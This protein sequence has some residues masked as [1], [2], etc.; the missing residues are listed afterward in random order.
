MKIL[1]V[2]P[3]VFT[4]GMEVHISAL[5]L[6]LRSKG[7]DTTLV[8]DE[9]FPEDPSK[10]IEVFNSGVRIVA[11]P[12]FDSFNIASRLLAQLKILRQ[13]LK[14]KS[15][16]VVFCEGY[17]QSLPFYTRYVKRP[18]GKLIFHDHMDGV[19][20][21]C[22]NGGGFHYPTQHPYNAF[23]RTLI[24]KS[25]LIIAGCKRAS[26]NFKKFYLLDK[27]TFLA[28]A[29]LPN[30]APK[31]AK[32]R[33]LNNRRIRIGVFGYLKPQ[34]GTG[35][36]LNL[37]PKLNIG[38]AELHFYGSDCGGYEEEAK[39]MGIDN[40]VFHPGYSHEDMPALMESTDLALVLSIFEGYPLTLLE[41]MMFGVPVVVTDV[42]AAPEVAEGCP[43]IRVARLN[44]EDVKCAIE[45]H[46]ANLRAGKLSRARIQNHYSSRFSN[47][48]F[49]QQYLSLIA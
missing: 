9:R 14:P 41:C 37:W 11:F 19:I 34:K 32:E 8:V 47:E 12:D 30:F 20:N 36:L 5:A 46:V 27:P 2:A 22:S 25:D 45:E 18:G 43:D 35:P 21:A 1:V 17:G 48:H 29:L 26:E 3:R 15:F 23:F 28:P 49:A 4:G 10:P 33:E 7:Y 42:G 16:D 38:D 40:V 6:L 31:P 13:N 39:K 24:N 44:D